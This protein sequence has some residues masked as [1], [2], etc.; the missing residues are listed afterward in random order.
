M[1]L[2]SRLNIQIFYNDQVLMSNVQAVCHKLTVNAER[3][4]LAPSIT[5]DLLGPSI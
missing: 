3:P 5:I 2:I 4:E 1:Y